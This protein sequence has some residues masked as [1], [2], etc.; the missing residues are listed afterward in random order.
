M[1][2]PR[3]VM[4]PTHDRT[5]TLRQKLRVAI[6]KGQVSPERARAGARLEAPILIAGRPESGKPASCLPAKPV[7]ID[8][9]GMFFPEM[10]PISGMLIISIMPDFDIAF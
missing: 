2:T 3:K 4:P 9:G 7:R 1:A 10:Q 6:C 5:T 8:K